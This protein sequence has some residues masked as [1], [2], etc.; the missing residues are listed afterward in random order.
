MDKEIVIQSLIEGIP[1]VGG[2]LST[3]YFGSKQKR[4]FQRIETFYKEIK[5]D[6]VFIREKIK[7]VDEHNPGELSAI[8]E[9]LHER[10]EKEPLIEK[11]EF[12]KN[13]FKNT[14]ISPVNGNYD[15]RKKFLD[16]LSNVSL[17]EADIIKFLNQQTIKIDSLSINKLGIEQS[18]IQGSIYNL[19]S[20]GLIETT[21]GSI[22]I[23]GGNGG[24]HENIGL[25]NFGKRFLC[26]CIE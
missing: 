1:Y 19:K 22:A 4:Q 6:I 11:R 18:I 23:G 17:L 26:F 16:I 24:I 9:Q 3:L 13:Y 10:I 15:E 25:S 2:S 7:N 5:K 21:L 8:I 14:L 20:W 12:Y